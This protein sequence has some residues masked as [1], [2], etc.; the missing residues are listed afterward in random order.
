MTATT[1]LANISKDFEKHALRINRGRDVR[2]AY[3]VVSQQSV[4]GPYANSET[5]QPFLIGSLTKLFVGAIYAQ[6]FSEAGGISP[7]SYVNSLA[8]RFQLTSITERPIQ[9]KELLTHTSGIDYSELAIAAPDWDFA[10]HLSHAPPYDA[11]KRG[12]PTYSNFGAALAGH[13][14]EDALEQDIETLLRD[15]IWQP[16]EM[17]E[18]HLLGT[19]EASDAVNFSRL[20]MSPFYFSAGGSVSTIEDMARFVQAVL[21]S[22]AKGQSTL[23]KGTQSTYFFDDLF[24]WST[25]HGGL[26][27]FLTR[28]F[29]NGVD[30]HCHTGSWPGFSSLLCVIPSCNVGFVALCQHGPSSKFHPQRNWSHLIQSCLKNAAGQTASATERSNPNNLQDGTYV[31]SKLPRYG[32][33]RTLKVLQK[34]STET[35]HSGNEIVLTSSGNEFVTS[36]SSRLRATSPKS[37]GDLV[38][39]PGISGPSQTPTLFSSG[40]RSVMRRSNL[41]VFH[42]HAILIFGI[43]AVLSAAASALLLGLLFLLHITGVSLLVIALANLAVRDQGLLAEN[44]L[45]GKATRL[46]KWLASTAGIFFVLECVA[47][48]WLRDLRAATVLPVLVQ[49][50]PITCSIW[51]GL[52][53]VPHTRSA[54]AASPI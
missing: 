22:S 33:D 38:L 2:F 45:R 44:W 13:L 18:T 4:L 35:F 12:V 7:E 50:L 3:R 40:D 6:V 49:A 16:L 29:V 27:C 1:Y 30:V 24:Q 5:I 9:I 31:S 32:L 53:P 42:K 54:K 48:L 28:F 25:G 46:P 52:L 51:L 26:S 34:S 17:Q 19:E 14:L 47:L 8:K 37:I 15:R 21:R 36:G 43:C 23:F 10:R 41:A 11:S 20:Q 39:S